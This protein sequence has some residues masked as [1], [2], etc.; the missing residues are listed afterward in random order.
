VEQIARRA[1]INKAMISYH[2]QGK[3]GL[4]TAILED[5]F[6]G[7][8]VELE[9]LAR[10][11]G[12]A[13]ELLRRFVAIIAGH[14][15]RHPGFPAMLVR[16]VIA[17][18]PHIADS[19]LPRLVAVFQAVRG[20]VEKGTREG[21]FRAVDPIL[22]HL[23]ILGSLVFFFATSPMRVRMHKAGRL[24]RGVALPTPEAFVVHVQE[25]MTRGLS[26]GPGPRASRR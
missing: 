12:G 11:A 5:L 4:Y 22:T 3:Q 20:I 26:A 21:T 13:D 10:A 9:T 19:M 17:G 16:E 23:T 14:S 1:G 8:N 18:G 7:I 24:P 6:T 15:R 2:F 25:L